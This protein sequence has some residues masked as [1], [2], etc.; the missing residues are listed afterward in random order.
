MKSP[1]IKSFLTQWASLL[2]LALLASCGGSTDVFVPLIFSA[3]LTG[4]EE[5]P[6]NASPAKGI[7]VLA[8]DPN[9]RSFHARVVSS[10]VADNA[11]HIHEG[12]P[13]VAGP[14]VIPLTK[15]PGSVV[16]E[17]KGILTPAQEDAL[18]AGDLNYYF[19]VHSP[20]FPAGEIRG[21][22]ERR[23]LS[24]EQ[25]QRA[26]QLLQELIVQLRLQMQPGT[27]TPGTGSSQ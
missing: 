12:A 13:G 5:T 20:T 7:G 18:R 17:A 24:P 14:I 4:V 2:A 11:A 22:I 26:E 19:N 9:D 6:P 15:E 27:A 3:T 21:Q 25:Q 16:W 23:A 10:G 8:F 1:G